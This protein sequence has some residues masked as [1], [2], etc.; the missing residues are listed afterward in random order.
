MRLARYSEVL[1]QQRRLVQEWRQEVLTDGVRPSSL[2]VSCPVRWKELE[3]MVGEGV[4]HSVE[5]RLTLLAIDACWSEHL[6]EM[7]LLRDEIHLAALGGGIP[8]VEYTRQAIAGFD[9]LTERVQDM[10]V[11]AFERLRIS[12]AGIDWEEDALRGP[13]ATWTYLVD[14]N[15]FAPNVMRTLANHAGIALWAVLL[16]WPLLFVWGLYLHLKRRRHEVALAPFPC[17][18]DH[19]DEGREGDSESSKGPRI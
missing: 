4:L 17:S 14:D 12:A 16:W 1:E 18:G 2:E 19:G 15:A 11:G 9:D 3:P 13:T 6:D 8:L 5:R 7:R 10:V